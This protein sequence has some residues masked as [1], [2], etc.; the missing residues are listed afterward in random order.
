MTTV[1]GSTLGLD[2]ARAA[3]FLRDALESARTH[4]APGGI[5]LITLPAP[6]GDPIA[7]WDSTIA[8][9]AWLWQEPQCAWAECAIGDVP[10]RKP[11]GSANARAAI[12]D[13]WRRAPRIVHPSVSQPPSPRAVGGGC[14]DPESP[15]E[16]AWQSFGTSRF[17]V[18][19]WRFV[20]SEA[21]TSL[22]LTVRGD[23]LDNAGVDRALREHDRISAL[24]AGQSRAQG[25]AARAS[26]IEQ[27]APDEWRELVLC[28]RDEICAG[29]FEKL[30]T[31]RRTRITVDREID[32]G[33]VLG[34]LARD[35]RDA[36]VFGLRLGGVTFLGASPETLVTRDGLRVRTEALAGTVPG[37]EPDVERLLASAK[38]RHEQAIV[39]DEIA[40]RLRAVCVRVDVPRQPHAH[41]L[42][43]VTHLRT[44][45]EGELLA[46]LRVLDLVRLLHPT[47]AVA[48]LPRGAAM[49]WLAAHERSARGWY[50]GPVGWYDQQGDGR[51]VVAIRS[52]LLVGNEALVYAG[53]GIV[54]AS[55]PSA[56]YEET[57]WK[58]R[59]M[60]SALLGD[61][62]RRLAP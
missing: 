44:P 2:P 22:T 54:P 59:A 40:E 32:A 60:T 33:R 9:E 25:P 53:A 57:G 19:R 38:D 27:M 20:R 56:E 48:G 61:D 37:G 47:P 23:E 43:H 49:R 18:P 24:L 13:A 4:A 30:V 15:V 29:R 35:H 36:T 51:F 50:A 14:F 42:R 34:A 7:L 6:S 45:I 52:A 62:D 12:Q 3:L 11:A 5:A 8:D 58:L 46:P 55:D 28:A 17:L 10:L 41:R 31:A 26:A 16:P 1:A 21:A 39:V